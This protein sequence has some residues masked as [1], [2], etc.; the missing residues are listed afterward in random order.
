MTIINI[1]IAIII[2]IIIVIKIEIETI[3]NHKLN[4]NL[5]II[6][7]IIILIVDSILIY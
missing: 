5:M 4:H 7:K 2:N 3:N 6:N 1:I